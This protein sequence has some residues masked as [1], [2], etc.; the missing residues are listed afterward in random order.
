MDWPT[1]SD[2]LSLL[3]SQ[4]TEDVSNVIRERYLLQRPVSFIGQQSILS[5]QTQ[6]TG[7]AQEYLKQSE[8]QLHGDF[9]SV[10]P[11]HIHLVVA[12]TFHQM[13]H[14]QENQSIML[15]YY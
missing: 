4:S 9:N 5:L 12:N 7:I 11:P 8:Q 13:V 1:Q 10:L 3:A 2:D 6:D 14:T 15:W